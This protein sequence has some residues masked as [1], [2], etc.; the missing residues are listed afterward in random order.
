MEQLTSSQ[1]FAQM[2]AEFQAMSEDD[3]QQ[4]RYEH[5]QGNYFNEVVNAQPDNSARQWEAVEA[6]R[7]EV[8][9]LEP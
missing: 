3:Q 6:M 1:L 2:Q 4:Y 7:Q 9:F 5:E 8:Q